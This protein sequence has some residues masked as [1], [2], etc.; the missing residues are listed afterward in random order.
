[1]A[2]KGMRID[3]YCAPLEWFPDAGGAVQ[4]AAADGGSSSQ[5]T[6]RVIDSTI[7]GS[8][9]AR[10]DDSGFLGS[11]HCPISLTLAYG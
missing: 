6:I 7:L 4:A 9:L 8:G 5:P 10:D 1:M 3:Y 2:G 11:D